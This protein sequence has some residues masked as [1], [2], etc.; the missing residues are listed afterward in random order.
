MSKFYAKEGQMS[1]RKC[2]FCVNYY[3]PTNSVI[4]PRLG[5]GAWEYEA[6]VRKPCRAK[7][8]QG[9]LSNSTCSKFV[10]KI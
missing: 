10:C 9:V 4:A 7:A 8:N 6:N 3:D 1:M 5:T 2:A